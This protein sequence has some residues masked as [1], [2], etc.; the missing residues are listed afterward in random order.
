MNDSISHL[1]R[2]HVQ[3]RQQ[4]D[5]QQFHNPKDM[6]LSLVLEA[7]ELLELTQWRNGEALLQH[8]RDQ[9]QD[10]S[11]E[12]ADVLGWLLLISHDLGIDLGQAVADKLE[13]NARKYPVELSRGQARKWTE[14]R[15]QITEES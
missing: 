5:W 14:Y 9:R 8:L 2:L 1:T 3:F 6:I 12:L 7:S 4:R 11:D 13:K 15:D 10:V